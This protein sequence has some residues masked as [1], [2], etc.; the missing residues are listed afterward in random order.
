MELHTSPGAPAGADSSGEHAKS[1]ILEIESASMLA[2]QPW[3]VKGKPPSCRTEFGKLFWCC[4]WIGIFGLVF[5]AIAFGVAEEA[6]AKAKRLEIEAQ[7]SVA[8]KMSAANLAQVAWEEGN[9]EAYQSVMAT[10]S[11]ARLLSK[12]I[13]PLKY[14]LCEASQIH[15]AYSETRTF[16]P[17]LPGASARI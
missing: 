9:K 4:N 11:G 2:D 17:I 1:S 15:F 3:T 5:A 14:L 7:C 12:T 8:A 13:L 10:N 16:N 6:L